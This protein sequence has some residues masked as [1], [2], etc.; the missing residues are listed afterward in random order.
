MMIA[1]RG[2]GSKIVS[3]LLPLLPPEEEVVRV[4][5]LGDMPNCAERYLFCAGLLRP[6]RG[7]DQ[8]A[9]EIEESF[10]VNLWRVTDDIE[11]IMASNVKARVCVIGSESG[12]AGSFDDVYAMAK[13][14]L[15]RFVETKRLKSPYQQLVCIA[16]SIIQ[17]CG[18]TVRR[19]DVSNLREKRA[20]HPKQRFLQAAEVAKLVHFTLYQDL[21]YLSGVVIRLNGGAHC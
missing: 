6:K 10:A 4:P 21:G 8:T 16:P 17:D 3:E 11:R 15:H 12:F 7:V 1:I 14:G 2:A 9:D 13:Q 5:R 18:M 19:D 20:R